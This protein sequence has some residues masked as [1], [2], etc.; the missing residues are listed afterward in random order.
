MVFELIKQQ[1]NQNILTVRHT[2]KD[3]RAGIS[4]CA[5]KIL[6]FYKELP[7]HHCMAHHQ[8]KSLVSNFHNANL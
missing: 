5:N 1:K 2:N 4:S 6:T 7:K 8:K 3:N